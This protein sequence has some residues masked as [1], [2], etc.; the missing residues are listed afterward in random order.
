MTDTVTPDTALDTVRET[1]PVALGTFDPRARKTGLV[2]VDEV[3][4]F[5][6]VGAGPLAPP[7]VDAQVSRVASTRRPAW[8][9]SS[10][11]SGHPVAAFLDTHVPGK[12]EPP[13]PPH[14]ERGTAARKNLVPDLEWLEPT[15]PGRR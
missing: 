15:T 7:A 2:I 14:C 4:G 12:P 9:A 1:L 5:A 11:T 3:N 6:T 13:Y 8:R 10:S